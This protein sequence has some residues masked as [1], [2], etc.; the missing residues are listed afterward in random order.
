MPRLL[1]GFVFKTHDI[2]FGK[3]TGLDWIEGITL[4]NLDGWEHNILEP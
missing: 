2:E 1:G 4:K 3:V